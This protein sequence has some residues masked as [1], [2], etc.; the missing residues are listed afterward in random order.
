MGLPIRLFLNFGIR[1]EQGR[2]QTSALTARLVKEDWDVIV[3]SDLSRAYD[4]AE[5]IAQAK[6]KKVDIVDPRLL[7]KGRWML[8]L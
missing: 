4:T 2:Q 8:I 7:I 3:A 1:N 6:G 5:A